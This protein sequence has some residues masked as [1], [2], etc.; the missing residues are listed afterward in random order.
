VA[1]PADATRRRAGQYDGPA[2]TGRELGETYVAELDKES[3]MYAKDPAKL[4]DLV[5]NVL[6]PNFDSRYAPA[7]AGTDLAPP[8]AEQRNVS[9]T[10]FYHSLFA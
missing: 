4:D 3:A 10:A 2:G 7:G 1:P 6:L 8:R 9:S 5:A